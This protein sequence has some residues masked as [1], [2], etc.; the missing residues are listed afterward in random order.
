VE[1]TAKKYKLIQLIGAGIFGLGFVVFF[2]TLNIAPAVA[3]W[4]MSVVG[5]GFSV[6]IIGRGLAWWYHD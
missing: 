5:A 2:L 1:A 3:R 6:A 4:A